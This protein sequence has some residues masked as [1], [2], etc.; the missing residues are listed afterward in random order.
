MAPQGIPDRSCSLHNLASRNV[1]PVL[2]LLGAITLC[3]GLLGTGGPASAG[4]RPTTEDASQANPAELPGGLNAVDVVRQVQANRARL[5]D[6]AEPGSIQ[7]VNAGEVGP[8]FPMGGD[9]LITPAPGNQSSSAVAFGGRYFLV[10]WQDYLVK[11]AIYGARIDSSGLLLDPVGIVVAPP[12]PEVNFVEDPDVAFDGENFLVVWQSHDSIT[13][14]DIYG[15]RVDTS[16]AVLDGNG[17]VISIDAQDQYRPS[18]A[19]DGTNYFVVWDDFRNAI[20]TDIYGTRVTTDGDVLDTGGILIC[21]ASGSQA[22]A[23]VLFDGTRYFVVW[24]DYRGAHM[25][26]YGGRVTPAGT[27][28]D[29]NGKAISTANYNQTLPKAAFDGKKYFVVWQDY[30]SG[31]YVNADIYGA[32][33]DTTAAVIAADASGKAICLISNGLGRPDLIF[34]GT[35]YL[36]VWDD[37]ASSGT[38]Y[39]DIY[40]ARV[41]TSA[42]VLGSGRI[43]VSVGGF[44]PRY[45]PCITFDGEKS[46][47]LWSDNRIVYDRQQSDILG[48]RVLQDGSVVGA[49]EMLVSRGTN[50]QVSVA[51]AYGGNGYFVVWQDGRSGTSYDIYGTRLDVSG[52]VLDPAGIAISTEVEDQSFPDVAYGL[53]K[54]FVVWNDERAEDGFSQIYGAR[55]DSSGIVRDP[56]GV[57]IFTL[58]EVYCDYPAVAF[59]GQNYLVVWGDYRN[60]VD[61]DVYGARVDTAGTV[62]DAGGIAICTEAGNQSV[63]ALASSGTNCLVAWLDER[64]D[65]G[66][67]Y[68]CRV[69][70]DG[71]VLDGS[72]LAIRVE[73]SDQGDQAVAF[74]GT[75][76][77]VVWSDYR[78]DNLDIYGARVTVGG[79]VLDPS[80]ILIS[81]ADMNQ[82]SPAVAFDGTTYLVAWQ[83]TRSGYDYYDI[84]GARLYPNGLVIDTDGFVISA[85]NNLQEY[86][87]LA[88]GPDRTVL[89]G[90]SSF[91]PL[92]YGSMRIMG[93]FWPGP[94]PVTFLACRANTSGNAVTLSWQ[95]AC[96]VPASS[97][98]VERADAWEGDYA[99]LNL[100]VTR[101]NGTWFSC[102][103]R[104]V[105]SG[106][107]YWYRISLVS[108]SGRETYGPV[109]VRV[110]SAPAVF[111]VYQSYPNPFNPTCFIRFD[112]PRP[113]ELTLRVFDAGGRVVRTIVDR[114]VG[115][116]SYIETWD[117]RDDGGTNMPSGVY[118]YELKSQDFRSTR[119]AV[120]LR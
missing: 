94:T 52:S 40:C 6:Q 2:I 64:T 80:G 54:Y 7:P 114:W 28:L 60:T 113:G 13:Q 96:D 111:A 51:V 32:R 35:N 24:A 90:Y 37:V 34:D 103:D 16:G 57:G 63:P 117:G 29:G 36:V 84:Y 88:H 10:V 43:P 98:L 89:I 85:A 17:F 104:D 110:E 9:T 95:V 76:Y 120:M 62:L 93:N 73:T 109:E 70:P 75:N 61:A 39:G 27:V 72:G 33:V 67:I 4:L 41:D 18:V 86:P 66:D 20:H 83:D 71:D 22:A 81:G 21:G 12:T 15:S 68:G 3:V 38:T 102:T 82:R 116:G 58:S 46:L 106:A 47:V 91:I 69:E 101:N 108:P 107:T 45:G 1:L 25:D 118:F 26:I 105:V 74:D 87:A 42:V 14:R 112:V 31:S 100:E 59:D 119:K 56:A 8:A 99:T 49:E 50:M 53:G 65:D 48:A 11:P 23:D 30:R 115:S 97:F 55:V 77:L 92:P 19:F 78:G 5:A 44:W 79:S